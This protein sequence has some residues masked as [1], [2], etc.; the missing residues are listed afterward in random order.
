[1]VCKA[2]AQTTACRNAAMSFSKRFNNALDALTIELSATSS[3]TSGSFET[4]GRVDGRDGRFSG[5]ALHVTC[6]H[7]ALPFG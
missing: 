1:M 7:R 5:S 6:F 2:S 3:S 4:S